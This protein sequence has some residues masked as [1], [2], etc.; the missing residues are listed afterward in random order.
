MSTCITFHMSFID[1]LPPHKLITHTHTHTRWRQRRRNMTMMEKKKQ[2]SNIIPCSHIYSGTEATGR[3]HRESW[4][5]EKVFL[6]MI[7]WKR[8]FCHWN[9]FALNE[10]RWLESETC[11]CWCYLRES[12]YW[13]YAAEWRVNIDTNVVHISVCVHKKGI[14]LT[15]A[16]SIFPLH[17]EPHNILS[18]FLFFGVLC[19][20]S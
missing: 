16:L 1:F 15:A 9:L 13:D 19:A 14:F 11:R 4:R 8:N 7:H 12:A 10:R 2:I 20:L 5:R 3:S 6:F 17:L 18:F